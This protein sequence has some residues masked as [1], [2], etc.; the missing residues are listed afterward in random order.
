[1]PSENRSVQVSV[2]N[3]LPPGW[4]ISLVTPLPVMQGTWENQD[5]P[6][7]SISSGTSWTGTLVNSE[8]P[9]ELFHFG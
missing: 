9:L 1:M 3:Q 2:S 4:T 6:P 7:S 8:T 5:G